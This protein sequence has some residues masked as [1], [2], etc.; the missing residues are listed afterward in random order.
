[1]GQIA[2][3]FAECLLNKRGANKRGAKEQPSRIARAL[4]ELITGLTKLN[5][6][7]RTMATKLAL[8]G[9]PLYATSMRL[10]GLRFTGMWAVIIV[11]LFFIGDYLRF[12]SFLGGGLI[13]TAAGIV[14]TLVAFIYLVA[15]E[16]T[17]IWARRKRHSF[18]LWAAVLLVLDETVPGGTGAAALAELVGRL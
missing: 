9:L 14:G 17:S 4:F 18:V 7:V 8:M 16:L 2:R 11:E 1:S 6:T 10:M 13:S 12:F 3:F 15:I 5:P